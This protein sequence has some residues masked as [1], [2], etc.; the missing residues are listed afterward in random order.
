MTTTPDGISFAELQNMLP[1]AP[2]EDDRTTPQT[3]TREEI[4]EIADKC[5]TMA[6]DLGARG[7]MV[8]KVMMMM[9][10]SNLIDWHTTVGERMLEDNELESARAWF[11]DAGK[12]Q[13]MADILYTVQCGDDDF[14]TPVEN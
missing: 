11:R 6:N 2:K 1:D 5:L 13:A 9:T 7:P 10:L 4:E 12:C 14:L 8:H 3:M